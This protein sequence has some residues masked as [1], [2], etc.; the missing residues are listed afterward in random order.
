MN[1]FVGIWKL[2]NNDSNFNEFLK[3][4]GYLYYIRKAIL[5]TN[6]DV[7]IE[8]NKIIDSY[9][10]IYK[11]IIS[12]LYSTDEIYIFDNKWY[13]F[14]DNLLKKHKIINNI[15]YSEI[16]LNTNKNKKWT[17]E[18]VVKGNTMYLTRKWNNNNKEYESIQIF[19]KDE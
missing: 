17:E 10:S 9:H 12:N 11:K 5:H 6:I 15:I 4:Y 8:I 7:I 19:T 18:I 13:E 2:N 1:H 3:F 14:P 16:Y